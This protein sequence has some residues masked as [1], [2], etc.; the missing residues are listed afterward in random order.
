MNILVLLR[1]I[2]YSV[3]NCTAIARSSMKAQKTKYSV[4]SKYHRHH[5]TLAVSIELIIAKHNPE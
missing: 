3:G 1:Y 2:G 5:N 4:Q